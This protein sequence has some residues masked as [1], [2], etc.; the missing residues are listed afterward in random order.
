[1]EPL[2]GDQ[3]RIDRDRDR[4]TQLSRDLSSPGA[5]RYRIVAY[6]ALHDSPPTRCRD[7]GSLATQRHKYKSLYSPVNVRCKEMMRRSCLGLCHHLYLFAVYLYLYIHTPRSG[8]STRATPASLIGRKRDIRS[9]FL[10]RVRCGQRL[11]GQRLCATCERCS[12]PPQGSN[13]AR[14][15]EC[16]IEL[17]LWWRRP[18]LPEV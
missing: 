15:C 7:A 4:D 10:W 12:H 6:H 9:R 2:V 13:R 18:L 16:V 8:R 14:V 3:V 1:M 5:P 17:R 11:S